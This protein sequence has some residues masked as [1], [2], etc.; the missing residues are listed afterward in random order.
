M[1]EVSA[2][3]R[4]LAQE[5]DPKYITKAM[6]NACAMVRN[7]AVSLAPHRTGTLQRSIDF[8]VSTEGTE[9]IIYTNLEYAPYVEVGTG[10]YATKGGGR[11]TPW[12]YQD[13]DGWHITR[14]MRA[15]PF[16]EPALQQNTSKIAECFEGLF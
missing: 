12:A 3:L 10:I 15:R 14:G 8:E 11:D 4:K 9:G 1:S 5:L 16:M 13:A 6:A 7:D 2:N